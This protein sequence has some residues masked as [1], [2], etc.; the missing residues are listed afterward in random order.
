MRGEREPITA[1][2]CVILSPKWGTFICMVVPFT[3]NRGDVSPCPRPLWIRPYCICIQARSQDFYKGG[4]GARRW[5]DRRSRARRGGAK[6]R[7]AEGVGLGRGAVAPPQY[8]GL[9]HS[10]QKIF[11]KSTFKLHIFL[12]FLPV[13]QHSKVKRWHCYSTVVCPSVTR[14]LLQRKVFTNTYDHHFT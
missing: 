11:E 8:G 13:R 5:R 3:R 10:P 4:G 2:K 14:Q 6:R 9:G 12:R 1:D 7:S